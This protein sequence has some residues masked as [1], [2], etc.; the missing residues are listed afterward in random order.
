MGKLRNHK[1]ADIECRVCGQL[2][3]V[4]HYRAKSAKYCGKVC[5]GT[6][7]AKKYLNKT[8]KPWAAKN[9]DGHR[10]KSTSR[11]P[12]GHNPWNKALKG[13]HLSPKSEFKA[14]HNMT[15]SLPIGSVTIRTDKCGS[16]RAWIKMKCGWDYRARIVYMA[17]HGEIPE[18][19]VVH[20]IDG[21]TLN[22]R[23][24]NLQ[25]LTRAE[26]INVHSDQ[27]RVARNA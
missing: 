2:F 7:Q 4:P 25:A 23:P 21:N 20:H 3:T 13:I 14:G 6:A 11:F 22:D 12:K 10:H 19:Y 9:L 26:H 5:S 1:R 24:E 8:P 15:P 17:K 27:L 18:G 16:L